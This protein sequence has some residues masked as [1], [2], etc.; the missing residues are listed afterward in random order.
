V[1][2]K[3]AIRR[4]TNEEPSEIVIDDMIRVLDADGDHTISREEAQKLVTHH[5]SARQGSATS[6]AIKPSSTGDDEP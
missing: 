1:E 6:A 4:V 5:Q 3:A 2:L